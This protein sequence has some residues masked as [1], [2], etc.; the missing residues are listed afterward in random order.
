M[1]G[2]LSACSA[3]AGRLRM[4]QGSLPPARGASPPPH[5]E[6]SA[7]S[8]SKTMSATPDLGFSNS[9]LGRRP[10]SGLGPRGG[11]RSAGADKQGPP[12]SP[13]EGGGGKSED[14]LPN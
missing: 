4:P 11:S 9:K 13:G 12:P 1:G 14:A 8:M 5:N 2:A 7:S 10:V 6:R 3:A